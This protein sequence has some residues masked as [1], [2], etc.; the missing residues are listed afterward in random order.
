LTVGGDVQKETGTV[1]DPQYE[2][3]KAKRINYGGF[4]QDQWSARNRL[5]VTAGA[6]LEHNGSFGNFLAPRVS[7]AVLARQAKTGEV[8]GTTKLKA[9]FGLGL[10]EPTLVESFSQSPYFRGNPDLRPEKSTSFDAGIEQQLADGRTSIELNYFESWFRDQIAY[11]VTDP[12]TYEGTFFNVGRSRARG[13]ESVLVFRPA[14]NWELSATATY[15][16]SKVTAG[17]SVGDPAFATGRPLFRRPKHSGS[18]DMR[19]APGRWV[20]GTNVIA[21]GP[22][23]DSDFVGLGIT[24]NPGY[25]TLNLMAGRRIMEGS[26]AFV[27]VDNVLDHHYMEVLGYP[28]LGLTFRIGLRTR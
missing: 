4:L 20:F 7:V 22:R 19:W 26:L 17:G 16:D 25:G 2:P 5:F 9:N 6:R 15:L 11:A 21:V 8:W 14:R 27:A 23:P 10:K 18:F 28:A 13:V 24:R 1:G 12:T 3:L